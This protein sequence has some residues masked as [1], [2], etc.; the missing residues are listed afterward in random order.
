MS[1]CI[2]RSIC[3]FH[4]GQTD[5]LNADMVG[6]TIAEY[7]KSLMVALIPATPP[8]YSI[9][10]GLIFFQVEAVLLASIWPFQ[11]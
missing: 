5:E 6:I 4:T 1:G 7:F 2:P 10:F 9:A 8:E 11:S 3:V